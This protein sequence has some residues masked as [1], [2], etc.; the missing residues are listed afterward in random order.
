MS[1]TIC[2]DEF[3]VKWQVE[4]GDHAAKFCNKLKRFGYEYQVLPRKLLC[5]TLDVPPDELP[6]AVP[7]TASD[8]M[9]HL[10][11]RRL[12][13]SDCLSVLRR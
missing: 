1:L 10:L 8:T 13:L 7:S 3:G 2:E 9:S 5:G 6:P 12:R 11:V 4:A